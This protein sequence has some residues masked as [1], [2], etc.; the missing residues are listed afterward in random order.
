MDILIIILSS[1]VISALVSTVIGGWFS[2]RSKQSDYANAY[3]KLILERR[4]AAYEEVEKLIG[5]IKVAVVD[6]DD[7]PYHELF[8][9]GNDLGAAYKT[10]SGTMSKALWLSDEL[11][12]LTRE[13]NLLVYKGATQD[14][15]LIEFGKQ[16]YTIIA[17]LRTNLEKVHVRDMLTLHD[18]PAFLKAKKPEDTYGE[19]PP[20]G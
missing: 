7:R 14:L 12:K 11:F 16:N 13:L 19:L 1:T 9:R 17:K 5:S 18:A 15:G 4:L 3:Y 10:L 20:R 6:T 8:S 2:L